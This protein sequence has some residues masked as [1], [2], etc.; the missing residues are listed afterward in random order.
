MQA[1]LAL[2]Q[3]RWLSNTGALQI[4]GFF[5]CVLV[6]VLDQTMGT[7]TLPESL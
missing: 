4:F 3:N 6:W 2:G 7:D 1:A 5:V